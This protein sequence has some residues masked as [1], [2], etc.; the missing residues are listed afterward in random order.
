MCSWPPSQVEIQGV[1]ARYVEAGQ[2]VHVSKAE[3]LLEMLR[4]ID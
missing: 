1:V 2:F 4:E 3:I